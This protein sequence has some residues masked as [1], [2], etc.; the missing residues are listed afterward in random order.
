MSDNPYFHEAAAHYKAGRLV[1]ASSACAEGLRRSPD[2][3][4]LH[5]LLGDVLQSQEKRDEAI[6]AYERALSI[7]DRLHGAWF[8]SGCAWLS[9]WDYATAL[10]RFERALAL[11]PEFGPA[12][13]NAGTALFNLGLADEAIR[14]FRRSL[15][16]RDDFLPRAAIATVIP[17]SP[18][19]G[20]AAVLAARRDW[21]QAHLPPSPERPLRRGLDA[22][23]R[24]RIGYLSSFFG[25]PN[26]MK[27][28]WGLV[29]Q[30]D[31]RAFEVHLFSDGAEAKCV[32]YQRDDRDRYHDIS[33]LSN[34]DAAARIEASE[35]DILV[36][37]NGYSRMPRLEVVA[38]RPA[39]IQVA[40]FNMFATSGMSCFDYL[41]GDGQVICPEEEKFYVERIARVPGCHLTFDVRYPVPEVADPPCR[42]AGRL[43]F[44]SFASQHKITPPVVEAWSRILAR[45]PSSRL[46][47][48]NATLGPGPNRAHLAGRFRRHGIDADRLDLEGPADHHEFLAAYAR[49]DVALDT[50]PYNGGTT[51]TE[52]IWQGVPVLTFRGD[53][54]ASRQSASLLRAAGLDEF[55]ADGVGDF[56]DRAVRLAED[57][58]SPA[59]L[60][61]L[62]RGMRARLAASSVCDTAAFAR[63]MEALFRQFVEARRSERPRA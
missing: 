38:L 15:E 16:L 54:W 52:A 48:K 59:R 4:A 50:F 5:K 49:I 62:R 36:D 32:G 53:R 34:R 23:G 31:R 61:D 47:L 26:W 56:V 35:I 44:G 18:E 30:H 22:G 42:S 46:L 24:L 43:T 33:E 17:G 14:R 11:A 19:A 13:H 40:W 58:R 63:S 25:S 51:T 3:A 1:E 2:E 21:Y 60:T 6:A 57:P 37:L 45:S 10:D 20:H 8:A 9:K 12:A 7:D 55:V 29:N 41:V 39:P 28:V 27:P